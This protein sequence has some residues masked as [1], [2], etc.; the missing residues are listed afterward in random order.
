MNMQA[1][2]KIARKVCISGFVDD[3]RMDLHSSLPWLHTLRW[4]ALNPCRSAPAN[5]NHLKPFR[6]LWHTPFL[7]LS[8]KYISMILVTKTCELNINHH[9]CFYEGY[10]S[11]TRNLVDAAYLDCYH[12]CRLPV[13]R[14]HQS[15]ILWARRLYF[16]PLSHSSWRMK[17]QQTLNDSWKQSLIRLNSI[18]PTASGMV[19]SVMMRQ[20]MMSAVDQ[21]LPAWLKWR[22]VPLSL[23]QEPGTSRK[24]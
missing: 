21:M 7:L 6:C 3:M 14:S 20:Q 13:F 23:R 5:I 1:L 2:L 19:L 22:T 16:H 8:T 4:R 9:A 24:L 15:R 17:F 11:H 18:T 10:A 12:Q